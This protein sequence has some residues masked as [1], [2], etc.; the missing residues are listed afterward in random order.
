MK[1]AILEVISS[2]FIHHFQHCSGVFRAICLARRFDQHHSDLLLCNLPGVRWVQ[3]LACLGPNGHLGGCNA[4][5]RV[6]WL[7]AQEQYHGSLSESLGAQFQH[8]QPCAWF[9]KPVLWSLPRLFWLH[10]S[11]CG[12]VPQCDFAVPGHHVGRWLG[13]HHGVGEELWGVLWHLLFSVPGGVLERWKWDGLW[14]VWLGELSHCR[15][16]LLWRDFQNLVLGTSSLPLYTRVKLAPGSDR[17]LCRS[18]N[19]LWISLPA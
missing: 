1:F 4:E 2:I 16:A 15:D 17:G 7:W 9:E 11:L 18:W 8:Q 10:P 5:S 13:P 3:Q 14:A 6:L 12:R 19:R